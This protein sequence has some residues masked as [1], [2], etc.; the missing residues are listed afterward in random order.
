M[1][2]HEPCGPTGHQLRAT[3]NPQWVCSQ[4][5]QDVLT[6]PSV[7]SGTAAPAVGLASWLP[8]SVV[9]DFTEL[10]D[11]LSR[12]IHTAM[13]YTPLWSDTPI[14]HSAQ[15]ACPDPAHPETATNIRHSSQQPTTQDNTVWHAPVLSWQPG[16]KQRR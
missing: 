11:R 1:R 6:A 9:G 4:T 15:P 13:V 10:P 14:L 3:N 12:L 7:Y 5:S 2:V 16:R 8:S